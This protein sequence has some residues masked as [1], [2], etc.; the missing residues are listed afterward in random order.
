MEHIIKMY[1][2]SFRLLC[3]NKL[4]G[5]ITILLATYVNAYV[6]TK[7]IMCDRRSYIHIYFE[8]PQANGNDL[9]CNKQTEYQKHCGALQRHILRDTLKVE[10]YGV[11]TEKAPCFCHDT[12][13]PHTVGKDSENTDSRDE[14][15]DRCKTRAFGHSEQDYACPSPCALPNALY[16]K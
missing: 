16:F 2:G 1:T 5:I 9:P 13:W 10:E 7:P 12:S 15:S 6:N 3:W 8:G 4:R 11:V 14:R